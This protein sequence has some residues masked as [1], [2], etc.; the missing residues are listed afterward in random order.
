MVTII[1]CILISSLVSILFKLFDKFKIDTGVAILYNYLTCTLFGY[2]LLP[3]VRSSITKITYLPD[4]LW[5]AC[6]VGILYFLTFL[7][8]ASSTRYNGITRTVIAQK[9][10]LIVPV[11]IS[12]VWWRQGHDISSP[13]VTGLALALFSVILS[14]YYN[15]TNRP[16]PESELKAL[17][18]FSA[19]LPLLVF[20]GAG[21]ADT[22]LNYSTYK[23]LP[24]TEQGLFTY[25][26]FAVSAVSALIVQ[27]YTFF[28]TRKHT[29]TTRN[30]VA[31]IIL[32]FPNLFS[33]LFLLKL[34]K[35]LFHF[36]FRTY[37]ESKSNK[38]ASFFF[39]TRL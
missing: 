29:H 33:L 31:G 5:A 6:I 26:V 30:I 11:I 1:T 4:W 14:A 3:G 36:Y 25:V 22:L 10:S 21:L 16:D 35:F 28:K 9:V 18:P 24:S 23:L 27:L 13:L 15:K 17:N 38:F 32:G 39:K 2:F 12:L 37:R 19:F 8:L 34:C 7:L 20:A